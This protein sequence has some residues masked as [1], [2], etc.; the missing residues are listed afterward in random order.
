MRSEVFDNLDLGGAFYLQENKKAQ[1]NYAEVWKSARI[2]L[3]SNPSIHF[4]FTAQL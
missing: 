1:D 2:I 3:I 4:M